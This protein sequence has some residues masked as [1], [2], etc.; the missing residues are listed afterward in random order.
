ME[1]KGGTMVERAIYYDGE[2]FGQVHMAAPWNR[3]VDEVLARLQNLQLSGIGVVST[4]RMSDDARTE[5]YF[6]VT[7][8]PVSRKHYRVR[9]CFGRAGVSFGRGVPA[10]VVW[11]NDGLVED[12]YPHENQEVP[13]HYITISDYFLHFGGLP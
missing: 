5:E 2:K 12:V 9:P 13:G 7:L 6:R 10:L 8:G 4:G 3:G 1:M 11:G